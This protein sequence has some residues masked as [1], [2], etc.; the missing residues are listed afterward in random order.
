MHIAVNGP[1]YSDQ[2]IHK[3]LM[4]ELRTGVRLKEA[5]EKDRERICAQHAEKC[6]SANNFGLGF[7]KMRLVSV[8]PAWEY[9][10]L[11]NKYGRDEVQSREFIKDYQKRFPHLSPNKL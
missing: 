11:V 10:N 1:K 8:T 7:K 5:M 9:F 2:E 3:A 6:K 4:E